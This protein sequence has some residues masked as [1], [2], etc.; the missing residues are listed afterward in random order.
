LLM[1]VSPIDT[2]EMPVI[3]TMSPEM[4]SRVQRETKFSAIA[5]SMEWVQ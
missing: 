1:T 2:S 3:I 5:V 4:M